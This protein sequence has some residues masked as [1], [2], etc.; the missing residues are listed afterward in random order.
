MTDFV[1]VHG[2]YHGAWCWEATIEALEAQGHCGFAF[3]LP[4]H[5]AD[6]TPRETVGREAYIE[7]TAVFICSL[8]LDNFVLV[9]HSLAGTFLFDVAALFPER[10]SELILVAAL[11]LNAGERAIDLIPESRRYSY[12][13]VAEKTADYSLIV[14]FDRAFQLYFNDLE[15][16]QARTAYDKLTP[17]PFKVYLDPVTSVP[18]NVPIRYLICQQDQALPPAACLEWAAKVSAFVHYIDAGHDVMLS[19][20]QALAS[21]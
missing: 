1:L 21:F 11:V 4:G 14:D 12:Y 19:Q 18:L 16:A 7:K 17:Q 8:T 3:D 5:G 15:I 2:G 9:G 20:P 13:E 6:L 10:I